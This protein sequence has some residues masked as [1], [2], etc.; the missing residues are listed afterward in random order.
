MTVLAQPHGGSWSTDLPPLAGHAAVVP[1]FVKLL[2]PVTF[3]RRQDLIQKWVENYLRD[4]EHV[5]LFKVKESVGL[6]LDMEEVYAALS[7]MAARGQY[8]LFKLN[9]GQ[10]ALREAARAERAARREGG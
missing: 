5:T 6:P 2:T 10:K 3:A 9:D 1:R 8:V 4:H 7:Q